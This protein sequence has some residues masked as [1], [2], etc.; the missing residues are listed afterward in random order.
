M[1]PKNI[2]I[3]FGEKCFIYR[4]AKFVTGKAVFSWVKRYCESIS[5]AWIDSYSVRLDCIKLWASGSN[6]EVK[7]LFFSIRY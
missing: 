5:L 3:K 2:M 1:R 7:R 4:N 6:L